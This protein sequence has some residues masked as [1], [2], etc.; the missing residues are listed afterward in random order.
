[1]TN[2]TVLG[3]PTVDD[4]Y[5]EGAEAFLFGRIE[6]NVVGQLGS[7]V[8]IQIGPGTA[9]IANDEG[10]FGTLLDPVFGSATFIV[11]SFKPPVLGDLTGDGIVSLLDVAQF[12]DALQSQDVSVPADTN[13]DGEISLLDVAPFVALLTGSALPVV[14]P[15]PQAEPNFGQLADVNEDGFVDLRD[16]SCMTD[17]AGGVNCGVDINGD[18]VID[19]LDICPLIHLILKAE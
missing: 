10:Q 9:G 17:F 11:D 14:D 2:F 6:F 1:M 5:D 15:A 8:Q 19:L 18:G 4:G 16:L 13:C 12:V 7:C 3:N